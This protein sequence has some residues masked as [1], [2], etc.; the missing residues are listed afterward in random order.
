MSFPFP[1]R[2]SA[3]PRTLYRAKLLENRRIFILYLYL[4]LSLSLIPL[5]IKLF[6][7]AFLVLFESGKQ[8]NLT[9]LLRKSHHCPL[10]F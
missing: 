10:A 7:H 9:A 1:E 4:G 8:N 3:M 5:P 2:F 6:L